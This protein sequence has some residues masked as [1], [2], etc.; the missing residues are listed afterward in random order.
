MQ[1]PPNTSGDPKGYNATL[2][3]NFRSVRKAL[4]RLGYKTSMA[5]AK[6]PASIVR[7]FQRDY[8]HCSIDAHPS[9]GVVRIDGKIDGKDGRHP[10]NALEI[11]LGY[12]LRKA[13][14]TKALVGAWWQKYCA[15]H[16]RKRA[17]QRT[18]P[19]G[20]GKRYIEMINSDAGTLRR[21]GNDLRV[22][23]H[24]L[25]RKGKVLF[26]LASIPPQA[27]RLRGDKQQHWYPA[28]YRN[29]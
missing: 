3:P 15:V 24:D 12:A 17:E 19:V 2:F 5:N 27:D 26:A 4:R 28:I 6:A 21:P 13:P 22:V 10:L 1:H 18:G 14:E 7:H 8:N 11:A 20:E 29:Q 23:I 16:H 9:W 25:A